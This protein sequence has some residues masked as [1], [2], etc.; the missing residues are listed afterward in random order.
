MGRLQYFKRFRMERSLSRLPAPPPLPP[1]Y[2][3]GA[4]AQN[5]LEAHA[6]AKAASFAGEIDADVFPALA[7]LEGCRGLMRSIRDRA[8]FCPAATWLLVGPLGYSGTVQ[9]VRDKSNTGLIQNLGVIPACRGSGLGKA[10]LIRALHGFRLAGVRKASL[11]VTVENDPALAMYRRLGFRPY[12][13]VYRAVEETPEGPKSVR[14]PA[15]AG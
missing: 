8:G 2:G 1:G 15:P 14:R 6:R 4:W 9:G 7:S 13:T 10:L 11:E 5:L 12:K 3:W